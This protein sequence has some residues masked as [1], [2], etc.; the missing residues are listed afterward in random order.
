MKDQSQR[1]PDS[2]LPLT[3]VMIGKETDR[4]RFFR[5]VFLPFCALFAL[6]WLLTHVTFDPQKKQWMFSEPQAVRGDEPHYLLLVNSLLFDHDIDLKE[7]YARVSRGGL[8]AGKRF[9]GVYLYHHTILFDP[10]TGDHVSWTR[11]FDTSKKI[12]CDEKQGEACVGF[13]R[14]SPRFSE[15]ER[16]KE[17]S[18]HHSGFPALA[19]AFVALSRPRLDQVETRVF[20][21]VFFCAGLTIVLLYL[22]ARD[23]GLAPVFAWAG[24]FLLALCSTWL[25]YARSFCRR[26]SSG[27]SFYWGFGTSI[28]TALFLRRWP[29]GSPFLSSLFFS[30]S[31]LDGFWSVS[32][33]D[34]S[35]RPLFWPLL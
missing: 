25:P 16:V 31:A 9:Q 20:Y 4:L 1:T 32:G 29:S 3:S 23:L 13:M 21:F 6:I 30:W 5:E 8:E 15:M 24:I 33:R 19:A 7:D 18:Q 27:W 10:R 12:V 28:K 26:S 11:I 17:F 2:T 22:M 14:Q 34:V 35:G